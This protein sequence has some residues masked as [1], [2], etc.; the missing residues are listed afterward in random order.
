MDIRNIYR[1]RS[2]SI[3]QSITRVGRLGLPLAL[4]CVLAGSA[5][6]SESLPPAAKVG[7]ISLSVTLL[8]KDGTIT[9]GEPLLARIEIANLSG[10]NIQHSMGNDL[11]K[12]TCLEVRDQEGK[13]VAGTPRPPYRE[14]GWAGWRRLRTGETSSKVWVVT[15]LY[16][17]EEPGTYTVRVQELDHSEDLPVIAEDTTTVRVLP[18]DASRLEARCEEIFQPMR[19]GG[20]SKTGIP[21]SVRVHALYSVSHDVVLPYLDWMARK[22]DDRYACRAIRRV[23]TEKAQTLISTLA[24]REDK[25]G[26][27]ARQALDMPLRSR[28]IFWAM[29]D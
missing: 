23:G 3:R 11:W 18:L 13:L 17:F 5:G 15:S 20:C 16:Q 1:Q 2:G 10:H 26:V 9:A 7:D 25:V 12:T 4:T 21:D 27:A 8:T 29:G 24:A 14:G 19:K 22:W 6:E 28:N